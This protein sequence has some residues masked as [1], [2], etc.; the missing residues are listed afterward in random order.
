MATC[1]YLSWEVHIRLQRRVSEGFTVTVYFFSPLNFFHA[2]SSSK[3]LQVLLND[4]STTLYN[5]LILH[6]F[7]REAEYHFLQISPN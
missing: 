6:V 2:M 4:L 5:N 7:T 1:S 3:Q